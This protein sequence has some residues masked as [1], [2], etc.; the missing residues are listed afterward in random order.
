MYI[1]GDLDNVKAEGSL[2]KCF[3]CGKGELSDE[4]VE[5]IKEITR[6]DV[7]AGVCGTP[8]ETMAYFVCDE[9]KKN[10]TADIYKNAMP[11]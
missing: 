10:K 5:L 1:L 2:Y 8:A 9:C 3:K 6:H 4:E 11:V 7:A